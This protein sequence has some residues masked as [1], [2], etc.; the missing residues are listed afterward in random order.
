MN[1]PTAIVIAAALISGSVLASASSQSQSQAGPKPSYTIAA[2]G[3]PG[4]LQAWEVRES[5]GAVRAC[6]ALGEDTARNLG[7]NAICGQWAGGRR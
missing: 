6:I 2:A 7:P 3:G 4:L 1:Y 5:D